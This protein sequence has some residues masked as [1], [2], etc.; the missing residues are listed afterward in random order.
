MTKNGS[1]S[2]ILLW[3]NTE[4]DRVVEGSVLEVPRLLALQKGGVRWTGQDDVQFLVVTFPRTN[5]H[6]LAK[7]PVRAKFI[8]GRS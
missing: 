7:R 2:S 6:R 3:R 8:G 5:Y 1:L 4:R